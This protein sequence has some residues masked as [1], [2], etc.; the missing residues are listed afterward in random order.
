MVFEHVL[1]FI[2]FMKSILC[3][4]PGC[5]E[6]VLQEGFPYKIVQDVIDGVPAFHVAIPHL[7]T[8]LTSNDL[9][10]RLRPLDVRLSAALAEKYPMASTLELAKVGMVAWP[11]VVVS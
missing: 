2:I 7:L 4:T 10:G 6:Y 9:H 11:F 8:R 3:S 1:I 5:L